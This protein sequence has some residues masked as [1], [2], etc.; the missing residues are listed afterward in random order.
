[1][2]VSTAMLLFLR[3]F[4]TSS[5][6]SDIKDRMGEKESSVS[7]QVSSIKNSML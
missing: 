5:A 7:I 4:A 3:I 2:N 1:M 6:D